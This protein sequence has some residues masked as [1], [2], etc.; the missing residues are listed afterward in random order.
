MRPYAYHTTDYGKTWTPLVASN[1]PVRGYA[2]VRQGGYRESEPPLPRHRVRTL[3][4]A[5]T[6]ASMGAVQGRRPAERRRARPRDSSA[7][8]RSRHR[9]A[10][11]RHLDRRRHHAAARAD[12]AKCWRATSCSAS[13]ADR[14]AISAGGG[15]VNGDAAFVGPNPPD[16]AIITYYQKKRHIFGDLKIEVLDSRATS[17]ARFRA[18]NAAA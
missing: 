14:A 8:Q 9:D 12:A 5:S 6:A 13:A 11:P 4:L 7:R 17:S 15:W 1:S 16:D 10:W 2:H 18:A 3:D